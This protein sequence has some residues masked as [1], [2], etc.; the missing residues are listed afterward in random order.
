MSASRNLRVNNAAESVAKIRE[1]L[2]DTPGPARDVVVI[3]AGTALYASGVADSI[4]DGI[5][6]AREAVSSGA[7]HAKL[8]QFASLTQS[9]AAS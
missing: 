8:T 6:R 5:Q 2:D 3:N 4:A 7:A 1:A 9:L